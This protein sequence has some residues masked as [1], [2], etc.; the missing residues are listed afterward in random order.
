MKIRNKLLLAFLGVGLTPLI[1]S[2]FLFWSA[3]HKISNESAKHFEELATNLIETIERNLFER[4]GDVQ[5]FGLN[6]IIQDT[7]HWYKKGDDNPIVQVMNAYVDTYDIYY[8]T[9]LVDLEGK[10][11]AVN[12]RDDSG[13]PIQSEFIYQQNFSNKSWL[14]D[15][16]A[17]RFLTN[18]DGSVTGTVVEDL[19]QDSNVQQVYQ[20]DG[21]TL[22]YTAPIRDASGNVIAVW[23]NFAK[24]SLAEDIVISTYD[25]L[26]HHGLQST[27]ITLIDSQGRVI[28]DCDPITHG[29]KINH[30]LTSVILKRN[31]ADLG[32]LA[33]QEALA[34]RSGSGLIMHARKQISQVCGYAPSQGALG[35]PGLG[36]SALLRVSE[37][38][39]FALSKLIRTE[40]VLMLIISTISV[41]LFAVFFAKML[42]KP[43]RLIIDR[44]KDIAQGEGDLTKRVDQN[45]GDEIGELGKWFNAFVAK[46]HDVIA[47][48]SDAT[49]EVA[50]AATEIAASSDEM[51]AGMSEQSSQV[52]QI[53]SAIE[54]MSAS[55]VE[56]ARKSSEAASNA[57]ESGQ[58]AQKG[59]E[60]VNETIAGM[61]AISDAVTAG[62]ASVTEL[63][64]RG[65][66]IGEIIEVINDIADQ[67]NLLALNAAIEAA[68][69]GEHGRGFAV[70]ADEVRKLADRTTKA[71]EEIAESI[72]AIQ[73]ETGEAVQRMNG[74]TDQVDKGVER[75]TE[76]GRSLQQ[77]VSGAQEVASM[78]QSIAAAAEEQ[79][80]ASEEVSRSVD[81]VSAV[82]RQATEGASQAAQAAGQLSTKAEQLQKLIGTFKT[83]SV[84]TGS[85]ST[86]HFSGAN[87]DGEDNCHLKAAAAEF[88]KQLV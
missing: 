65:E 7:E 3:T 76:A 50:A 83:G 78:I 25:R 21:L 41:I 10:V 58:V 40:L 59:G 23:K 43:I 80:A 64:K 45:R 52:M 54:E 8:L 1:I 62:A 60:V 27:E 49:R 4:Y 48:V 74:G 79:S 88:K 6:T 51:A 35:Y 67:T 69:A 5:A 32:V 84:T 71:T 47:E 13:Q 2:A 56:V 19:Y 53:S 82:T 44:I 20:D 31:L 16:L 12:N 57:S 34:G 72:K 87:S 70:V 68:R 73:S 37:A 11:I 85:A 39:A 63:G 9:V 26:H 24:W 36:W 46:I 81:A 15:A 55:V 17:G 22:G 38:E 61:N 42:V 75:A 28:V 77:I 18:S 30:D 33:A 14:R 66:Q 29:K 86:S